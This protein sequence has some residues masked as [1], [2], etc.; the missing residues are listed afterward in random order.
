[1]RFQDDL[2]IKVSFNWQ[3]R[4]SGRLDAEYNRKVGSTLY[5]RV[6]LLSNNIYILAPLF[7]PVFSAVTQLPQKQNLRLILGKFPVGTTD[8]PAGQSPEKEAGIK[9][10]GKHH[11]RLCV[12]PYNPQLSSV[13]CSS[14]QPPGDRGAC[15]RG[16][17][18]EVTLS[19]CSSVS[20][21]GRT[22]L[23]L[24][25]SFMLKKPCIFRLLTSSL[26]QE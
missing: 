23:S 24:C 12:C 3:F 22:G 5:Q 26:G 25:F 13:V 4:G 2:L 17:K 1:M 20:R 7:V 18:D 9:A 11:G 16:R 14:P 10:G 21:L 15:S 6:S 8:K 19:L